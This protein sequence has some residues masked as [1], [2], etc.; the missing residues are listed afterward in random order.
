MRESNSLKTAYET[1]ALPLSISNMVRLE[2][3]EPP[4]P[5]TLVSKT[6]ASAFR[7]GRVLGAVGGI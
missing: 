3:F 2:G 7:Q 1:V 4:R 5:R 6:S